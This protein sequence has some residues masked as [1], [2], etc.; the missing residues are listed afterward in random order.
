MLESIFSLLKEPDVED[1]LEPEIAQL[2]KTDKARYEE[3][4]KEW[5][6]QYAMLT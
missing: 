2:Y 3:T 5:T 6:R 1:P 4:A